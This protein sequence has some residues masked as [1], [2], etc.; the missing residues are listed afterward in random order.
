MN[1]YRELIKGLLRRF[2]IR[3][4]CRWLLSLAFLISACEEPLQ[5]RYPLSEPGQAPYDERLLGMWYAVA[6]DELRP[7]SLYILPAA[8]PHTLDVVVVGIDSDEGELLCWIRFAAH[9]TEVAGATYF[10]IMPI[11]GSDWSAEDSE[12]GHM[13]LRAE[14]SDDGELTFSYM[15]ESVLSR[16]SGEGRQH[17]SD[18]N[19]VVDI[20][21]PELI[22]L[23]RDVAA[24]PSEE[25]FSSLGIVFRRVPAPMTAA[26]D[27][28][29]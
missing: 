13:F 22:A 10:N 18:A 6:D 17:P 4:A 8:E 25:D 24:D 27:S 23:V 16:L 26:P 3:R 20:R 15:N 14:L 28:G 29:D 2:L 12:P 9:A 11:G 7:I 19:E 5:S 21:P 1:S